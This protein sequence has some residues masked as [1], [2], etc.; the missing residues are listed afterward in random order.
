MVLKLW[1]TIHDDG[2]AVLERTLPL[3]QDGGYTFALNVHC[4]NDWEEVLRA[5]EVNVPS[6]R[7]TITRARAGS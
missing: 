1:I 2:R 6:T 4:P 5:I 3:K 7:P